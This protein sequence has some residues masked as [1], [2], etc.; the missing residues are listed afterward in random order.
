[1]GVCEGIE[2]AGTGFPPAPSRAI[3]EA[4]RPVRKN[5]ELNAD[6]ATIA[7]GRYNSQQAFLR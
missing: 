1:L 4:R 3:S 6:G 2:D 7:L 5:V